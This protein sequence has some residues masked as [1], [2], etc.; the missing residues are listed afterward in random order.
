M[1]ALILM[2]SIAGLILSFVGIG[3]CLLGIKFSLELV[4]MG[5]GFPVHHWVTNTLAASFG[6]LAIYWAYRKNCSTN[7]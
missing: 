3:L 6:T 5:F 1:K 2:V 4:A 7:S